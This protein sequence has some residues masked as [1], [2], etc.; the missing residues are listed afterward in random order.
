MNAA[1]LKTVLELHH[2][3]RVT[4]GRDGKRANLSRADLSRANLIDGGQDRRGYRFVGAP[5]GDGVR[6]AAG[7]RWFTLSAARAHWRD[8]VQ[9]RNAAECLARVE[10]IAA[11]AKRRGWVVP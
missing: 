9:S 4:G 3:W 11:E 5:W 7:C 10:F 1:K 6:I 8:N 2:K